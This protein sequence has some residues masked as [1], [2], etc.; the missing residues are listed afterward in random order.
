MV[1]NSDRIRNLGAPVLNALIKLIK[2]NPKFQW[3]Y[4]FE[5]FWQNMFMKDRDKD[6]RPREQIV[7][8]LSGNNYII[9][10]QRKAGGQMLTMVRAPCEGYF[11]QV[12]TQ[13]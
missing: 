10:P 6:I 11:G 9:G 2:R 1:V 12:P 7:Q 8:D 3:G 13:K 5:I 4:A